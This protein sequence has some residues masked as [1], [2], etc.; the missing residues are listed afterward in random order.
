MIQK[1]IDK[2]IKIIGFQIGDYPK[3]SFTK[4]QREYNARREYYLIKEYIEF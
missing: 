4:F 3:K 1:C 2:S